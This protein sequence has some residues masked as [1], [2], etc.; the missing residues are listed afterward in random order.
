MRLNMHAPRFPGPSARRALATVLVALASA[1]LL[2]LG[3]CASPAGIASQANVVAADAA[4]ADASAT[5]LPLPQDWWRTFGDAGL[6][7]LVQRALADNPS[8]RSAD[9]RVSTARAAGEAVDANRA[10]QVNGALKATRQRYTENGLI[11]PPLAG[12]TK[13]DAS[14]QVSLGWQLDLFGRNRAALDAALGSIRAAEADVAAARVLLA[15]NV[16]RQYVQ[17]ARLLDQRNVAESALKQ[18]DDT[19]ALVR[20]RVQAGID[21]TVELRLGEGALPETRQQIEALDEQIVL[22]RHALA[23][24]TAQPMQALDTLAPQL[25]AVRAVAVPPSIPASLIG[26]RADLA[27]ARA[28]IEA[29][30]AGVAGAKA[31][32]YPDVDLVAFAGFGALGLGNLLEAGS[33]QYG[34][35]PAVTLPIFD[36]GRLRANLR[37]RNAELDGAIESYNAAL[38]D[39]VRDAADQVASL[40]SIE[41]QRDQQQQAQHSAEAAYNIALQRFRAGLGT[42]LTVLSAES[43]VLAQRRLAADLK[44]RDLDTQV[45]LMRSLGGGYTPAASAMQMQ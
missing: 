5:L 11:P 45:A 14:L 16:V 44:A 19:L 12:T 41:R 8:L 31:Q 20:Q 30:T 15:A 32:F 4:G 42:Y 22:V 17:L 9:A 33:R 39:A 26:Q 27:A 24:L 29:A 23:V 35:G 34:V 6:D 25:A 38:F 28:R 40:R 1:A 10:P 36:A 37:G 13:T 43:S 2:V 3:G 18:R 21:T 7:A